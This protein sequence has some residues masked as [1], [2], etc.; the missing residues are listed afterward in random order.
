MTAP[1]LYEAITLPGTPA[2][3][4]GAPPPVSAA[5]RMIP[6]HAGQAPSSGVTRF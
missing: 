3:A 1:T 6:H 4:I 5:L 2:S